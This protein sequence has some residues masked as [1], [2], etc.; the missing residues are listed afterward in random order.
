MAHPDAESYRFRYPGLPLKAAKFFDMANSL[1]RHIDGL[2]R[3]TLAAALKPRGRTHG[4][5]AERKLDEVC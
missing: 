1:K 3:R 5:S 4:K 2:T